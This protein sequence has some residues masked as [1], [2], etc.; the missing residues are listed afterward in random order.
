M[1]NEKKASEITRADWI[2]WRIDQLDENA[3][4]FLY[5]F[6]EKLYFSG[7]APAANVGGVKGA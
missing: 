7:Q 6:I 5:G 1:A 3:Q 4:A 2:K